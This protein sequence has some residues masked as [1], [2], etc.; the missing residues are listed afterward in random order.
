MGIKD[1]PPFGINNNTPRIIPI[2]REVG[3]NNNTSQIIQGFRNTFAPH[4]PP[5]ETRKNTEFL[6]TLKT[7]EEFEIQFTKELSQGGV[8]K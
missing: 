7:R 8:S 1:F 2:F 5:E 3:I 6:Y 4:I